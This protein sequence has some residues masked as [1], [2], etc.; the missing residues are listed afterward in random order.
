MSDLDKYIS[1]SKAVSIL[2]VGFERITWFIAIGRLSSREDPKDR[3]RKVVSLQD[4]YRLQDSSRHLL[5]PWLIYALVDPRDNS[6]RYVGRTNNPQNCYR[7]HINGIYVDSPT[8]HL[9]IQELKKCNLLPR[10]EILEGVE[11]SLE[12]A[13]TRESAW[14]QHFKNAGINLTNSQKTGVK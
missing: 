13:H 1:T 5:A 8:K 6:I 4:T 10:M 2:G 9:W 14:I 7:N 12:D 11:G 3:T